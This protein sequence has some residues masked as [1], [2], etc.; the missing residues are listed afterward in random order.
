MT[1]IQET[2][3]KEWLKDRPQIIKELAEKLPPW[4]E[5]RIKKTGQHCQIYS[6]SEKGTITV[7]VNGHDDKFVNAINKAVQTKVFGISPENLEIIGN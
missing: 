2:E 7:I 6:Y 1:G 5:Y 4:N 3:F